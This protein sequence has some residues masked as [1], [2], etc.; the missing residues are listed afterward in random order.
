MMDNLNT[1]SPSWF[2][3]AFA[4]TKARALTQRLEIHHARKH[5]SCFSTRR[6]QPPDRGLITGASHGGNSNAFEDSELRLPASCS[7]RSHP[8]IGWMARM[9]LPLAAY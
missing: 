2:F 3:E 5:G 7:G 4:P 6:G 9:A 1:R 8:H